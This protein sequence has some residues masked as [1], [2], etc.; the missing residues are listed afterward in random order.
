MSQ[1]SMEVVDLLLKLLS[2]KS[3]TPD[4]GGILKFIEN[5]L[6]DFKS[7]YINRNGVKNL[8]LYKKYNNKGEHLCFAGHVDVVPS[9]DGWSSNPFVPIINDGF[10]YGRGAQDMKSGVASFVQAVKDSSNNNNGIISI[11]LTSDEEGEALFGTKI[12]LEHL[13]NINLLPDKCIV[14]EPT[15]EKIFGDSIKIGRRGSINGILTIYGVQG[16]AAYPEKCINPIHQISS[17]L[18]KMAGVN[19]DDGDEDF[20]PSKFIITDIRS[21]MEVTNVTPSSLKIMFNIRNSTKISKKSIEDIIDLNLK[22]LNYKFELNQSSY[23]FLTDRKSNIIKNISDS[24]L[25]ITNINTSL[26]T[27][28]GTSDGRFIAQYNIDVVEFGV[29]NDRIHSIN[30]RVSIKEVES[31]YQ[32]FLKLILLN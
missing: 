23:P 7:I 22:N 14:A 19:L 5:Y 12:I 32:I 3:I 17:I 1:G 8:F 16:H 25:K 4:D 30:E 15:C 27:A 10:I 18:P 20:S 24:I 9:G 6:S 31:L 21:G 11:M 26:S 13:K 29:I 28:G 2:M